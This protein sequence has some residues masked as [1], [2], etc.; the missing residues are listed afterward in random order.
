MVLTQ[1]ADRIAV[2]LEVPLFPYHYG[3]YATLTRCGITKVCLMFPYHYGSYATTFCERCERVIDMFPYHY[4]SYATY[5]R[6]GLDLSG[7][8]F[9]TTMVLTQRARP[10]GPRR[11]PPTF[12]YHY[13]SYATKICVKEK[14][15]NGS[16]HTTMVLTQPG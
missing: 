5:T 12:P 14:P 1:L 3:S 4:G 2:A 7:A 16:F 11:R 13:G 15:C 8:S 10:P 9:H 6:F